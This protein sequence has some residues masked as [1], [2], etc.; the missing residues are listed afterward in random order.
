MDSGEHPVQGELSALF[1]DHRAGLRCL[2]VH[3]EGRLAEWGAAHHREPTCHTSVHGGQDE[4][5]PAVARACPHVHHHI[6]A[7]LVVGQGHGHGVRADG[8]PLQDEAALLVELHRLQKPVQLQGHV[9]HRCITHDAHG[10]GD[11]P[12]GV[13]L[14][15][16]LYRPG[17][18]A[19]IVLEPGIDVL[20]PVLL[21][22]GKL[23]ARHRGRVRNPPCPCQR[24]VVGHLHQGSV[25]AF[26]A[27]DH[28]GGA[29]VLGLVGDGHGHVPGRRGVPDDAVRAGLGL[30]AG[31]VAELHVEGLD[32]LPLLE[33][34]LRLPGEG[35]PG[36][37]L[38]A[39]VLGEHHVGHPAHLVH[40]PDRHPHRGLLQVPGTAVDQDHAAARTLAVPHHEP[41][42]RLGYQA[43]GVLELGVG[44]R[45]ALGHIR[46]GEGG[47]DGLEVRRLA[48]AQPQA[49]PRRKGGVHQ[50]VQL[51]RLHEPLVAAHRG[52]TLGRLDGHGKGVEAEG[53]PVHLVAVPGNGQLRTGADLGPQPLARGR[54]GIGPH[55]HP[56]EEVRAI[57]AAGGL[58]DLAAAQL[59]GHQG[60]VQTLGE[61]DAPRDRARARLEPDQ[62]EVG[63]RALGSRDLLLV[64]LVARALGALDQAAGIGDHQGVDIRLQ[65]V[66]PEGA[67]RLRRHSAF[68]LADVDADPAEV[69]QAL[70]LREDHPPLDGGPGLQPGVHLVLPDA[71]AQ[72]PDENQEA[73]QPHISPERVST[74]GCISLDMLCNELELPQLIR[75]NSRSTRRFQAWPVDESTRPGG[76]DRRPKSGGCFYAGPYQRTQ[77]CPTPL[78]GQGGDVAA[79][80]RIQP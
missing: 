7:G 74:P 16:V 17:G 67:V 13:Q 15:L 69:A 23:P 24:R 70:D 64:A 72:E 42:V 78:E 80:R 38:E 52:L 14:H 44:R 63:H 45:P 12:V 4:V 11:L 47:R 77:L 28:L 48:V 76:M 25:T 34:P 62:P 43:A 37:S 40:G 29:D 61:A 55:R 60:A 2:S 33:G 32:P 1:V 6:G 18:V 9:G 65:V 75:Q 57:G 53:R 21:R 58:E 49:G 51:L 10:P 36:R 31:P 26:E 54:Q 68:S 5:R 41:V 50:H 19:R 35:R 46:E 30:V 22:L 27:Q 8:D 56:G 71:G 73:G 66:E 59:D 20:D 39:L 79:K 3:Q